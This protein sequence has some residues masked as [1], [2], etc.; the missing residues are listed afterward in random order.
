MKDLRIKITAQNTSGFKAR[1]FFMV[2]RAIRLSHKLKQLKSRAYLARG[3][4]SREN[5]A[6]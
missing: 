2:D 4:K 3:K 1:A 5:T 6:Q